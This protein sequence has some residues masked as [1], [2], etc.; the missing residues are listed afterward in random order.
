[1]AGQDRELGTPIEIRSI[2]FEDSVDTTALANFT[3]VLT[4][5]GERRQFMNRPIHIRTFAGTAQN[6]A[7]LREPMFL[8]SNHKVSA[9]FVKI[10]GG[11]TAIRMYLVGAQYFPWAPDLMRKPNSDTKLRQVI[12]RWNEHKKFVHPYWATVETDTGVAN[13]LAGAT[14][15]FDI[16]V[17]AE[18][19]FEIFTLAAVSTGN[20]AWALS[21]AKTH[22]SLMNGQST[23]T[24]S[25][26]NAQFPTM[27][28]T[29]YLVPAGQR[30]R[31]NLTDL[32]AAPNAVYFTL[33]GRLI[34]AP[35]K[36]I[37]DASITPAVG[38]PADSPSQ[39]VPR[40]MI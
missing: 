8:S 4:D 23:L 14:A 32:S 9:Y 21:D 34:Y 5:H 15:D 7:I 12:T 17:G 13:L 1:M 6:P 40:P 16:K 11:A 25:L 24:N 35:F 28:P 38:T 20:F 22:Q 19:H 30:L 2:V 37:G 33:V 27:L 26:G 10:A 39:I 29:A 31:L 18:A 36:D 3:I